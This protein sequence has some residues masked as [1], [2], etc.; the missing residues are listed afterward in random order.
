MCFTITSCTYVQVQRQNTLYMITSTVLHPSLSPLNIISLQANN[1]HWK[2]LTTLPHVYNTPLWDC[3]CGTLAIITDGVR[4]S[5]H[6]YTVGS[7]VLSS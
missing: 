6:N 7:V 3:I 1:L 2:C 4:V 5:V